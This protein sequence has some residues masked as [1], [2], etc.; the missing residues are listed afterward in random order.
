[1]WKLMV[2]VATAAT[3]AAV[4][5]PPGL[6]AQSLPDAAL[7]EAAARA[8]EPGVRAA[9]KAGQPVSFEHKSAW[10]QTVKTL[11]EESLGLSLTAEHERGAARILLS[12]PEFDEDTALVEVWFGRCEAAEDS[13]TLK[14]RMYSFAFRRQGQ[15]WA[16]LRSARV[17]ATEGSCDGEW[18]RPQ[19]VQT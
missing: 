16:L 9:L 18:S 17:G 5:A 11:L 15:D 14:I 3:F 1:M 19:A 13:E 6:C 12:A 10:G 8:L 7:A 2:R 4:L